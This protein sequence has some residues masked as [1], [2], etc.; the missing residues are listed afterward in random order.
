MANLQT[1]YFTL[2]NHNRQIAGEKVEKTRP[3]SPLGEIF[4]DKVNKR[5]RDNQAEVSAKP[6]QRLRQPES[7]SRAGVALPMQG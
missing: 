1:R 3:I 6:K 4:I 5:V 2:E 7:T